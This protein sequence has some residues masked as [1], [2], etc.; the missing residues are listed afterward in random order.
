MDSKLDWTNAAFWATYD[1]K[2]EIPGWKAYILNPRV[3]YEAVDD[4]IQTL[5]LMKTFK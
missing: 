4:F 3:S 5:D 1:H 2:T